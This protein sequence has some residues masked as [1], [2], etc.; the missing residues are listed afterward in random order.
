MI[1]LFIDSQMMDKLL[2][3]LI[4]FWVQSFDKIKGN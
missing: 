2:F 1:K 3:N 4:I